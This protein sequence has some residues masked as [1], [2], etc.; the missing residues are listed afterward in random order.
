MENYKPKSY[1]LFIVWII[2]FITVLGT[3]GYLTRNLPTGTATRIIL[4]LACYGLLALL[5]L[6]L[7]TESI[8]WFTGISYEQAAAA[9][10]VRRRAYAKTHLQYFMAG[11]GIFLSLCALFQFQGI[12]VWL[13][14]LVFLLIFSF[15]AVYSMRIKL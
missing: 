4:L 13:D 10:R 3:V 7:K 9:G 5:Y 2:S 15:A 6:I 8:Y 14:L 11:A 1:R 12:S